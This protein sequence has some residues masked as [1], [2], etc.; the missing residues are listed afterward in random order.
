[1]S[2]IGSM[3]LIA[4]LVPALP[5]F[6]QGTKPPAPP[7]APAKTSKS[8]VWI[9]VNFVSVSPMQDAQT[10]NFQTN[11]FG[12]TL[13]ATTDYPALPTAYGVGI[14]AGYQAGSGFGFAVQYMPI[15]YDYTVGL[16]ISVPSPAFFNAFGTDSDVTAETLRR[17]DNALDMSA[18]YVLRTPDAWSIRLFGGP[19]YFWISQE[20]VTDFS[21]TQNYST[22][23]PTNTV[24]ITTH[25]V[26][27]VKG[28]GWGGHVGVDVAYFFNRHFGVGGVFRTN[29]GN[30]KIDEPFSETQATLKAG[31]VTVGGGVRI[32]F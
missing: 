16:A 13:S 21:F 6:A 7:H 4:L 9:D 19:T 31:T 14:G 1:M 11:Y 5:A 17:K 12:E 15:R 24:N 26:E 30:V 27:T 29:F 32:R 8:G 2:K 3:F 22:V 28:T 25:Q 18:T 20:M 23:V 10:Y